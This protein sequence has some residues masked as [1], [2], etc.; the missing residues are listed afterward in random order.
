MARIAPIQNSLVGGEISPRLY[1]RS[2]TEK[3]QAAARAVRNAIVAPHGGAYA[4]PGFYFLKETKDSTKF[5]RLIDFEFS[6]EQAYTIEMGEGYFRYFKNG[7]YIQD[8]E[9][10]ITNGD[11]PTGIASWTDLSTGTGGI[12]WD[13]VGALDLVPGASGVAIAEQQ[14]TFATDGVDSAITIDIVSGVSVSDG[15]EVRIGT[16]SGAS[17]IFSETH[18]STGIKGASRSTIVDIPLGTSTVYLQIRKGGTVTA[19]VDDIE[20][21]REIVEIANPYLESELRDVQYAQSADVMYMVHKD[22]QVQIM[23]RFSDVS[24]SFGAVTFVDGVYN[25][26]NYDA[27]YILTTTGTYTVGGTC[28]ITATGT[29]FAPFTSS[30]VGDPIRLEDEADKTKFF[31]AEIAGFTSSTIV[32]A[33]VKVAVPASLQ[34]AGTYKW[35]MAAF[36]AAN[37]YPSTVGLSGQRVWFG[38]TN[39]KP[40]TFWGS[41]LSDLNTFSLGTDDDL[42]IIFTIAAKK[43]HKIQWIADGAQGLMVGTRGGEWF[44]HGGN[45]PITP[46]NI[47]ADPQ[48]SRGS[49]N[50]QPI[51]AGYALLMIQKFGHKMRELKSNFDVDGHVAPDLTIMAEHLARTSKIVD[52]AYQAE[53]ESVIWAVLDDGSLIACTYEPEQNVVA[54]HKHDTQGTFEAITSIP[55][56]DAD[57]V[58]AIIKRTVNGVDKRYVEMLMP[59]VISEVKDAFFVDSGLTYT[60]PTYSVI[61]VSIADP[62]VVRIDIG[63]ESYSFTGD[64]DQ[65]LEFSGVGGTTELNGNSYTIQSSALVAGT[66]YDVTLNLDS[67]D[68]TAFISGGSAQYG[69][70]TVSGLGH[71]EAEEVVILA[72]GGVDDTQNVSSGAVTLSAPAALIHVGLSYLPKIE[73]LEPDSGAQNGTSMGKL[74]RYNNIKVLLSDSVGCKINDQEIP[75]REINSEMGKAVPLFSGIVDVENLGWDREALVVIEQPQP[76]PMNVLMITGTLTTSDA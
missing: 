14:I 53:R 34:A 29:G 9:N 23:S 71:L 1:G 36:T 6:D 24:W 41:V 58:Y 18:E 46:T 33:T 2:D 68:Y 63:S 30:M 10:L 60:G 65:S 48:T 4:R 27:T 47:Q 59:T 70:K 50:I 40:Q 74:K 16:T 69:T 26:R 57:E 7:G 52:I 61:D 8:T 3:Y 56:T 12:A 45:S 25:P 13:G 5:S 54:W 17:D 37:G 20:L 55:G 66:Q 72:D 49:E 67:S 22:H 21:Y 19:N 51:E 15:V 73:L 75:F 28:T 76:L 35:N 11:F 31:W 44:I 38:S 64:G 43:P 39:A 32:T 42:A 62:C